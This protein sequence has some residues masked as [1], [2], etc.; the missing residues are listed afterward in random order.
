MPETYYLLILINRIYVRSN[1]VSVRLLV[2]CTL[3]MLFV[4]LTV[5]DAIFW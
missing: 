1:L 4:R 3:I 5:T 2:D